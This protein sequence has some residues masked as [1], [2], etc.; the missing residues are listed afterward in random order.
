MWPRRSH[1]LVPLMQ[2]TGKSKFEWMANCQKAF[3]MMKSIL[4][5][6]VLMVYPNINIPF[7]IS[8][9]ASYYQIGVVIM[10]QGK[11]VVYWSKMLNT[12]QKNYS[13]MEKE[14]LSVV[15]C[16]KEYRSVIYGGQLTIYTNSKNLT[17]K[18]LNTQWVLQWL[19]FLED[20]HLTFEYYLSGC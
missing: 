17:F 10:Q 12:A 8:T 18:T 16:L 5:S 13:I 20:F 9:D 14:M 11:P 1:L 7:Q 19:L 15:Y 3:D 4:A 2:L 6:D